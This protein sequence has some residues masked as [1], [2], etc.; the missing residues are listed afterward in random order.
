MKN[1]IEKL[2]AKPYETR[3]KILWSSVLVTGVIL[4]A[5]FVFNLKNT[6]SNIDSKDLI[7]LNPDTKTSPLTSTAYV[8]VERVERSSSLLKVYFNYNNP[9]DDILNVS[10]LSDIILNVENDNLIAQKI[11]DRQGNIF[12]QKIL[13]HTQNFGILYFPATTAKNGTL[14]LDQMFME[15]T[16]SDIFQQTLELNL[17][18]LSKATNVR[19]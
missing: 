19:N 13:S 8:L 6:V 15:K 3:V 16:P 17:E 9:N 14:I 18:E 2:Q 7:K 12:V 1:F 10:K 11:T 4:V 5:I